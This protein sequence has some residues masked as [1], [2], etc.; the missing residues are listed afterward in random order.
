MKTNSF[1][2]LAE[3]VSTKRKSLGITQRE[4]SRRTNIDNNTIAKIEKGERKKPNVL[5]LK[6][7]SFALDIDSDV[8]LKL[9]GYNKEEI[10]IAND[11]VGISAFVRRDDK[12]IVLMEEYLIQKEKK[13]NAYPIVLELIDNCDLS[14]L[15]VLKNKSKQ[16]IEDLKTGLQF[17][18]DDIQ[19]EV[20]NPFKIK[21]SEDNNGNK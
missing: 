9:A 18:R 15:K 1:K 14:T 20:D 8:L 16:E 7:L 17:I 5:S 21:R 19:K 4:L 13:S 10:K 12:K 3:A 11:D 6:K 2:T